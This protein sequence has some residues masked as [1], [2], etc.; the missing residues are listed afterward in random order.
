MKTLAQYHDA[1]FATIDPEGNVT[2]DPNLL[3][4]GWSQPVPGMLVSQNYFDLAGMSQDDKTM[5]IEGMAVQEGAFPAIDG[6]AGD[7]Y[8]LVDIMTSI[9]IDVAKNQFVGNVTVRGLG[10][11]G[12]QLNFEHV[13]YQRYRRFGL[14]L[15]VGQRVAMMMNDAQSGSNSPTA[16]DR[17]Y[18]YRVVLPDLSQPA[19]ATLASINVPPARYLIQAE[20][21]EEPTYQHMMR[22]KRSYDLQQAPDRD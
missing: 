8:I 2:I 21:K 13:L 1:L 4:S 6:A 12:A 15:D 17:I 10:F 9:P 11:P 7:N 5:F 3:S 22:L 18:C 16:S 14:D 19:P 20:A